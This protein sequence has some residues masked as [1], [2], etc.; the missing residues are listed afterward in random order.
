M[1]F[2][3]VAHDGDDTEAPARR[4]AARGDHLALGAKMA[5][6]G[7]MVYAGAL[8]SEDG[9]M[10]GSAIVLNVSDR[11]ELD[12]WLA[13]EPYVVTKVWQRMEI[14]PIRPAPAFAPPQ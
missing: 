3:L 5:A 7:T 6:A 13:V 12:A 10:I 1:H 14:T 9:A 8:L 11:A 4:L 2:L